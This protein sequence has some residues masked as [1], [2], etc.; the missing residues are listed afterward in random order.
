MLGND[1]VQLELPICGYPDPAGIHP[2]V[3]AFGS[4]R[5]SGHCKPHEWECSPFGGS[6]GKTL[7]H[8]EIEVKPIVHG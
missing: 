4:W 5:P 8:W 6:S 2:A 1:N 7:V 3:P